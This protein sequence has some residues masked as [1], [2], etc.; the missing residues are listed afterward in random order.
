MKNMK[1]K[2][3][4]RIGLAVLTLGF[5]GAASAQINRVHI[6]GSTAFRNVIYDAL[7]GTTVFDAAPTIAVYRSNAALDPHTGTFMEF[8]NLISGAIYI[9]KCD[10]SGSE[11]GIADIVGT[12]NRD[13]L[14]DFGTDVPAGTIS[15]ATPTAAQL[16]QTTV[17]IATADNSQAA[18]KNKTPALPAPNVVGI[19][20]LVW[21][22]N[23]QGHPYAPGTF[24]DYDRL[25]NI[26]HPQARVA[27]TGGT[28]LAL[29]TGN[30]ADINFVY[31]SGRDNNSG[32]RVNC[33]ADTTYGI[34]KNVSQYNLGGVNGAP[35][36]TGVG[37]GGQSSGGTLATTMGISGSGTTAD[38]INGGAHW[39]AIAYMGMPDYLETAAPLDAVALTLNGVAESTTA[40]QEG[41]YSYWGRVHV[42]TRTGPSSAA[43]TVFNKLTP[44]AI[45]ALTD[46][47]KTIN[48]TTMNATKTTDLS[49]PTHN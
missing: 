23:A 6:T 15:A 4:L 49:D 20:P 38:P 18:S 19:I 5:A 1:M 28:K 17:D 36:I 47:V 24:P 32:T 43:T 3:I 13:F 29:L 39:Y 37:N 8:S 14:K 12:P 44:A 31:V 22:K 26:T 40:I 41:Q 33:L 42:Y 25:V 7:S 21:V 46:G 10:W 9:I 45:G 35:T 34:T 27:L 16:V 11:A 2:P 48:I 30:A